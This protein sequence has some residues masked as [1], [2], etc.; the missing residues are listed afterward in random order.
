ML[1]VHASVV[2]GAIK[3]QLE[4][5]TKQKETENRRETKYIGA[6]A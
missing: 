6:G 4:K 2:I 3:Y 1:L 5:K